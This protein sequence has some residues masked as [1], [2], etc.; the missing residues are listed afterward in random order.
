MYGS[1]VGQLYDPP[2]PSIVGLVLF[3]PPPVDRVPP[4]PDVPPVD[5]GPPVAVPLA[6]PVP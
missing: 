1:D 4:D 3:D 6:P 2:E 5:G